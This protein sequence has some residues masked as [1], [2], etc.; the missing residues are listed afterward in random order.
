MEN[1]GK[2]MEFDSGKA[3]GTLPWCLL[4]NRQQY[5]TDALTN[6]AKSPTLKQ[7][8]HCPALELW[9]M[10][11]EVYLFSNNCLHYG[12]KQDY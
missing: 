10:K 6:W 3:L 8:W 5:M 11:C 12:K 9:F 1:D 4:P 2:I 7:L